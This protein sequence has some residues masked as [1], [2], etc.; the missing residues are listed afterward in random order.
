MIV[1]KVVFEDRTPTLQRR[2][3]GHMNRN[4]GTKRGNKKRGARRRVLEF[5]GDKSNSD[6][7]DEEDDEELNSSRPP[8]LII[9]SHHNRNS[10]GDLKILRGHD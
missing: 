9:P 8:A 2:P 1:E 6:E 10:L 3:N 7:D 5:L 4:G